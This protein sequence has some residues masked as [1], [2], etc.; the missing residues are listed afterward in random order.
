MSAIKKLAGQTLWYGLPTIVS[1]FLGY[2]MNM[3]LPF[4]FAQPSKTADITQVY[5]IIPF[6]NILFTYGMETAYFKYSQEKEKQTLYNTLSV[7]LLVSTIVFSL[8]LLLGRDVIA[9]AADLT[10]HPEYILWMTAIIFFDTLAT[11]PFARLRQENRPRRYAFVRV[12]GIV[13]NLLVVFT[14]L[15]FI[16]SYVNKHPDSILNL[17]VKLD[18]GIGYYLIGNLLGSLTTFLLLWPEIKQVQWEFH[19]E[20]WQEIMRYSYPLIIVGLGGM[21]N[22]MLSRLVYQHVVD[23]PA[24]QA[25]HELGVFAN[26]YRLAVLITIMIQAFRMAAE[27]FFFNQSK[28]EGAQKSYARVMKFFVIACCFMFLLIGLYLDALKWIITLKSPAW[29]EGMYIV[30][31]L[32]MG[33][34]FLGIYYNLSIWYK[35]TGK[36]LYGAYI[37]I[38]GAAITI[39]LNMLLI[40]KWH[41]LGAAIA[42]FTCYL[43]MMVSSYALG[44]KYY[45]VPY[46]KKKLISYLV[47]VTLIVLFHRLILSFYHPLW[48]SIATGT[49][50]L[51]GFSMFVAKIERRDLQKLPLIGRFV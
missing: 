41:Y 10:E 6:L 3:A 35:L 16:P 28:E 36:N 22:D 32:A 29:G 39:G 20:M 48:F 5:A 26:L 38:A 30:P 40:P 49:L 19:K 24:E 45:P 4:L 50:L 37:T 1:R 21:V 51:L 31:I 27:P 46:A 23:L 25:K 9:K 17:V 8:L 44:Q 13:V 18:I 11:L 7:S 43:V 2:L 15:G 33:N 14:F 12:A 42:T 34:I 47:L